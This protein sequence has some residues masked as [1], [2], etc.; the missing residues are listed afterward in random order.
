MRRS[1]CFSFLFLMWGCAEKKPTVAG[2]STD[3]GTALSGTILNSNGFPANKVKVTIFSSDYLPHLDKGF[4]SSA[5]TDLGGI[6]LFDSLDSG[7]YNILAQDTTNNIGVFIA[8]IQHN[9]DTNNNVGSHQLDSVSKIAGQIY[10]EGDTTL[11]F[12]NIF[13]KGSPFFDV[14]DS[15]GLFALN[16][17]PQGSYTLVLEAIIKIGVGTIAIKDSLQSFID[18][19]VVI[20]A[21]PTNLD[22]IQLK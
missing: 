12:A 18:S 13:I 4:I 2:G 17:T 15:L 14:P 20:S 6:F 10:T 8:D 5:F 19:V 11:L 22:S 16:K 1:I 7:Y 21:V 3:T 9:A